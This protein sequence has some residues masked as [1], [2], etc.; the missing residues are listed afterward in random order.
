M[1][2][3][4]WHEAPSGFNLDFEV[5]ALIEISMGMRTK[6]EV[7]KETGLLKLDRILFSS[8]QYPAN[9]GFIPQSLGEDGDPLDVMVICKESIVP[10]CLVPARIVGVMRMVDQGLVDDK[11][12]AVPIKNASTRNILDVEDVEDDLKQEFK[13]FFESYTLL[14]NKSVQVPAF[15]SK[16]VAKNLVVEALNRYANTYGK[17]E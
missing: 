5:N 17:S 2:T 6:Y 10:L 8:V 7:D 1:I 11:I 12:L 3:H 15:L 13:T 16:E 9:Y 4:P 14:E